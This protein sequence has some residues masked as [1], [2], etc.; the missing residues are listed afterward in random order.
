MSFPERKNRLEFVLNFYV[1]TEGWAESG[2]TGLPP[3]KPS[4]VFGVKV[5]YVPLVYIKRSSG[6]TIE[7]S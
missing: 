3:G 6:H 7:P 1:P 5:N 4:L 2:V